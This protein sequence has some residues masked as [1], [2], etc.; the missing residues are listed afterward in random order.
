VR[1][2]TVGA[3]PMVEPWEG[4]P[5]IHPPVPAPFERFADDYAA[6]F[7]REVAGLVALATAIAGPDRGEEL[8]Q[9]ALLRAHREWQR[10]ARYDKPGAWVRRVTIN[11]AASDRRRRGAEARAMQ[12]VAT[13]RQLPVPPPEVDGFWALVRTLPHRQ[14]AAVAL[15]YLDDLSIA[16]M[17]DA[18]GCA[19]GTAKAHLHK[20]RASLALHLRSQEPTR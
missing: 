14:A 13:R 8:A 1:V 19:E 6:F 5:G 9:E 11:L 2:M 16:E 15:H 18:L 10:I 4:E 20:A 7:R 17:A 12:R 3:L